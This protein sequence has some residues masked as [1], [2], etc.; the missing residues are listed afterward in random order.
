MHVQDLSEDLSGDH[1]MR[2]NPNEEL[3][4]RKPVD[5]DHDDLYFRA[6]SECDGEMSR[7]VR[8]AYEQ[9]RKD[10]E[11]DTNPWVSVKTEVPSD[12]R[13]VVVYTLNDGQGYDQ[14]DPSRQA[15]DN[16][17]QDVTHWREAVNDPVEL[18]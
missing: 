12:Y 3:P 4:V 2:L 13:R 14:Y 6:Q 5:I 16:W 18:L 8:W 9:G 15:W 7:M 10:K 17:G 11:L 1:R